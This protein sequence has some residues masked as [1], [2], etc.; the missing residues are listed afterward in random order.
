MLSVISRELRWLWCNFFSCPQLGREK[1]L[2]V[3]LDNVCPWLIYTFILLE[4][5]LIKLYAIPKNRNRTHAT[6]GRK[7]QRNIDKSLY[8]I[9]PRKVSTTHDVN[10][11]SRRR[12]RERD[13][14]RR[15]QSR[16]Y[17]ILC[18]KS[19][20]PWTRERERETVRCYKIDLLSLSITQR[21]RH[22]I[23]ISETASRGVYM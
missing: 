17:R 19:I 5:I 1:I 21:R 10:P 18:W 20:W 12:I 13:F 15:I 22:Y 3:F 14:T 7:R 11:I 2:I 6:L 9:A 16:L 8:P 23:G 4:A